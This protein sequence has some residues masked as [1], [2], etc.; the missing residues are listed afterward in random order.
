MVLAKCPQPGF[1]WNK[2]ISVPQLPFGGFWSSDVAIIFDQMLRLRQKSTHVLQMQ[3]RLLWGCL[4]KQV[5]PN[6]H[7]VEHTLNIPRTLTKYTNSVNP[8]FDKSL[9][10]KVQSEHS[11]NT[12]VASH[13]KPTC[14]QAT[15][16]CRGSCYQCLLETTTPQV[17]DLA[18]QGMLSDEPAVSNCWC[19]S[20]A[21]KTLCGYM[22]PRPL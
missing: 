18:V 6:K 7:F 17:V 14:C 2:G 11:K 22:K 15:S 9:K 19:R 4:S 13:L 8:Y 1:F 20:P 21:N 16:G 5:Q 3:L 10:I 12:N